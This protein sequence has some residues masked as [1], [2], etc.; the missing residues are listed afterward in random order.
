[1]LY[2]YRNTAT[3][4]TNR[5]N[6]IVLRC[7][8]LGLSLLPEDAAFL[9]FVPCKHACLIGICYHQCVACISPHSSQQHIC[10]VSGVS[11]ISVWS[12]LTHISATE[13]C[14]TADG[15]SGITYSFN[16]KE[17]A[18]MRFLSCVQAYA[19]IDRPLREQP[20]V[21][22]PALLG[23]QYIQQQVAEHP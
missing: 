15:L 21:W 13:N 18:R 16:S 8:I 3:S 20:W 5:A 2:K 19:M 17:V 10:S 23:P 9:R 12:G 11:R 1:M 22:S 6:S 14:C 4:S 7:H